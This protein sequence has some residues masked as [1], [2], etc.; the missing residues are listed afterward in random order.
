MKTDQM[1][2]RR[3][4]MIA[5]AS[6]LG[7]AAASGVAGLLLSGGGDGSAGTAGSP[8]PGAEGRR[9]LGATAFRLQ[10]L[11]GYSADRPARA[12]TA[13]RTRP[14]V[15]VAGR[16]RTVVLTFDDGP[17]A[18]WTPAVL[19]V[20]REHDV[21][22]MFF[23]VGEMAVENRKLLAKMA[24]QGH[25]V[26]N[27]SWNHPLLTSMSRSAVRSQMERTSKV[28]ESAYGEPPG[29]FRAPYGA[30]DR[31]TYEL[32]A[33]MGMEP[34]AW[35]VDTEDWS[36]P[37]TRAVVKAVEKG[38]ANGVVVLQHDGGGDRDQSVAALRT[39]LPKL[40]DAGYHVTVPR[41]PMA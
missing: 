39:Y 12:R 22:A 40:L 33:E 8:A 37:G 3:G 5:G 24:E 19:K 6:V 28:I 25:V 41:R 1:L 18:R 10:P 27:H 20:L 31:K 13:V 35:T 21:P 7:A 4:A 34:M 16:G 36:R 9:A 26:G 38:L 30:W 2:T 23:V 11:A 29:W 15:R 14:F 17:D 32:G